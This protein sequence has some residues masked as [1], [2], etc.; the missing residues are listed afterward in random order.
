MLALGITGTDT[1]IGK[2]VVG[3]AL[4]AAFAR[5][6]LRVGVMKPVET[7]IRDGAD[8]RDAI[9]LRQAA[10]SSDPIS[11]IAP[12]TLAEP[13]APL[14]AAR[15]AGTRIDLAELDAAFNALMP[16]RDVLIVEGAGGLLVPLTP[17][18]SFDS[19]FR[20]WKLPVVVVA[21]NR[22]GVINH[23]RLTV[24][25]A[26][27]A[28]LVV[29]AVVLK[30]VATTQPDPSIEQ[31]ADLLRELLPGV[32]VVDLPWIADVGDPGELAAVAEHCG[33]M[34]ILTTR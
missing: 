30:Q 25:A 11:R 21:A 23:A 1:G 8:D 31:N 28:S 32:P 34:G 19:L 29:A 5:R 26:T 14:A 6:G 15:R 24:A 20:R 2:T 3:C 12:I 33:L 27:A 10:G 13:L 22:L 9:R 4:A 16:G 17:E 7:G 18:V